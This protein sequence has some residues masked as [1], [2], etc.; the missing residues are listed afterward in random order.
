MVKETSE[1]LVVKKSVWDKVKNV[2]LGIFIVEHLVIVGLAGRVAAQYTNLYPVSEFTELDKRAREFVPMDKDDVLNQFKVQATAQLAL[3]AVNIAMDKFSGKFTINEKQANSF[4]TDLK[5]DR[6]K[7]IYLSFGAGNVVYLW[8]QLEEL[9]APIMVKVNYTYTPGKELVI[10]YK[11]LA[12][13]QVPLPAKWL[14]FTK[15]TIKGMPMEIEKML[16]DFD[17]KLVAVTTDNQEMTLVVEA[18]GIKD[19]IGGLLDNE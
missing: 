6:V 2:L 1:K 5:L 19:K 17:A 9:E 4:I 11:N 10:E 12:L 8:V 14:D 3:N 16:D 18:E 13:G 7:K 15:E